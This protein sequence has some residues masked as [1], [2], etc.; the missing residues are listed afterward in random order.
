MGLARLFPT[1][2]QLIIRQLGDGAGPPSDRVSQELDNIIA[3]A[4]ASPRNIHTN[5]ATTN[6]SGVGPDVLHTFTLDTPN[7]LLTDGDYLNVWYAGVSAVN[8]RDK[9]VQAQFDN[10]DYEGGGILDIDNSTGWVLFNRIIR[11][12]ATTVRIAHLLL[13]NQMF[14]DGANAFTSFNLGANLVTRN[15]A[16][17]VANLNNNAITMRVRSVV[18]AGA[19]AADVVQNLSIIELRQQ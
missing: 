18:G 8:D 6:S 13:V 7:R 11:T 3:W 9:A 16:L 4:K 14:S 1:I 10:Q 15:T 17:T 2:G 5:T 12:S 19:A